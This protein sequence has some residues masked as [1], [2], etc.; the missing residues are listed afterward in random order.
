MCARQFKQQNTN[1][2]LTIHYSLKS[3]GADTHAKKVVQMLHQTAQD[4]PFEEVGEII[5]LSAA[6]CDIDRRGQD[7][8]L[9]WLQI[10][11]GKNV[12]LT[13]SK[14]EKQES[15]RWM[16]V[17]PE[18]LIAFGTWPGEGCEEANFGLCTFPA[19]VQTDAGQVATNLSGWRWGAFC[20]SQYSSNPA[21]GGVPNFLRCHLSII[22]LLDKAKELGCLDHVDDEGGYWESRNLP[23]LVEQVGSWNQMMAAFGGL[24]KDLAPGGGAS[25]VAEVAQ[26]P[27]FEQ[28]EAAGQD[29]LP[30]ELRSLVKLIR[31]TGSRRPPT[32]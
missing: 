16:R 11:A 30:P 28:L 26:Y 25:V 14:S 4:L 15:S 20:K 32:S 7:D 6:E 31:Q 23:A 17:Q 5:D 8:P 29:K 22:A 13:A 19:S 10:Q 18:R 24:L 3:E 9:R 2:G 1:M 21:C 27:N 12:E